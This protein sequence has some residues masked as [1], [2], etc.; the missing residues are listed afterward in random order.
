MTPIRRILVPLDGS[1]TA[2]SI[3]P[4]ARRLATAL[5]ASVR[6]LYVLDDGGGD[7]DQI[8]DCV[9]WRLHRVEA[10][11]YLDQ[12]AGR[13]EAANL[14]V[15]TVVAEGRAA[16]QVIFEVRS[17]EADLIALASHGH[18]GADAFSLGG[19]AQKIVSRAGVSILLARPGPPAAAGDD[20][21]ADSHYR[22]VIL[23]VDL[24]R[25]SDW[26]LSVGARIA[27]AGGAEI[28]LVHVVSVPELPE[29]GSGDFVGRVHR[30]R[31]IETH[32]EVAREYLAS[33][34]EN[35]AAFGL[36]VGSRI[37]ESPTIPRALEE[38]SGDDADT[39]LVVSAH[40]F[41]GASPWPY[42]SVASHLIMHGRLPLLVLQDL[43]REMPLG[44]ESESTWS[45]AA[46]RAPWNA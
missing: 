46:S 35:L 37:L 19:I 25:R 18:G 5:G 26:A 41:S 17:W 10:R 12:A 14:E 38:I 4:H 3:L 13:L 34:K 24:S 1:L 15:D 11:S 21:A 30:T 33:T 8:D 28:E 2:E 40:G 45:S 43:P 44:A 42:G 6:L 23:P 22:K 39:L 32:H 29:R 20:L 31:L 36:E 16:R 9:E 27:R 7:G